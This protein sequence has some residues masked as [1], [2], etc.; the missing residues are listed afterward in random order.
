MGPFHET[1][2]YAD[3][4]TYLEHVH[5]EGGKTQLCDDLVPKTYIHRKKSKSFHGTEIKNFHC[6]VHP[7]LGDYCAQLHVG[8]GSH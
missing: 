8:Q 6:M 5:V 1:T 2:V 7:T 4:S 3:G